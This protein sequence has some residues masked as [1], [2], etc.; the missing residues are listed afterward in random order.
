M[1]NVYTYIG[2]L[3]F[4]FLFLFSIY[5]ESIKIE[6]FLLIQNYLSMDNHKSHC[7]IRKTFYMYVNIVDHKQVSFHKLITDH[8]WLGRGRQRTGRPDEEALESGVTNSTKICD[9]LNKDM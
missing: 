9:Q 3:S 1:M 2:G 5:L 6:M 8:S 7:H 4:L